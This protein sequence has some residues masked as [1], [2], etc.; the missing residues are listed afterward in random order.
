MSMKLSL[1]TTGFTILAL[2]SSAAL[3]AATKSEINDRV[4]VT[5]QQFDSFNRANR[6]LGEK[7]AG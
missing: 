4:S 2:A 7:A 1:A 5:L 6:S 3:F